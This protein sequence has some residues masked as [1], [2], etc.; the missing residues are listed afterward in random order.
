MLDR[1]RSTEQLNF[2]DPFKRISPTYAGLNNFRFFGNSVFNK[3]GFQ[4]FLRFQDFDD[5]SLGFLD[6]ILFDSLGQTSLV[7]NSYVNIEAKFSIPNYLQTLKLYLG[8]NSY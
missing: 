5:L 1:C 6:L 7:L 2:N 3:N 4:I 8:A